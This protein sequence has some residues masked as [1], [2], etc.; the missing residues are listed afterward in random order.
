MRP[1]S[2][3]LLAFVLLVG[4]T[5]ATAA[6]AA[7][8][9]AA[10]LVSVTG[11]GQAPSVS[12]DGRYVAYESQS[13]ATGRWSVSVRDRRGGTLPATDG[14]TGDSRRPSLSPDGRYLAFDTTADNVPGI[15]LPEVDAA[16]VV[17]CDLDAAPELRCV[18][19]GADE[20]WVDD[21]APSL[22]EGAVTLSW[23][24]RFGNGLWVT[25]VTEF[26]RDQ[27]GGLTE[28]DAATELTP[29]DPAVEYV[30][31]TGAR[32][33][34][35]ADGTTVVFPATL[36]TMY[37]LPALTGRKLLSLNGKRAQQTNTPAVYA[38]T[39]HPLRMTRVDEEAAEPAVS[40]DGSVL[41]YVLDGKVVVDGPGGRREVAAG[42]APTLS[43]DGRYLAY[44][45]PD[46]LA[47]DL[48]VDSARAEAGLPP[49]AAEPVAPSGAGSAAA[50]SADGSTVVFDS[51]ASLAAVDGDDGRDVYARD[52]APVLAAPPTDFGVLPEGDHR[53]VSVLLRHNGFG[54]LGVSGVDVEGNGFEV[55]PEESCTGAVLYEGDECAVG[56]RF[57][58]SGS[59]ERAAA[60]VVTTSS[61]EVRVPLTGESVTAPVGVLSA[62]PVSVTFPGARLALTLSVPVPVTLTNGAATPVTVTGI[63]LF[64]GPHA[65]DFT[66]TGCAGRTLEPGERC[67][68]SVV[69]TPRGG[70]SR[71][72]ALVITTTDAPGS[73]VIALTAT[74]ATP[75]L[76]LD[77]A[78][79]A[80]G[81]VITV[82]G[83][84][85]PPGR[86]VTVTGSALPT[87]PVNADQT[88]RFTAALVT[89]GPSPSGGVTGVVTGTDVTAT[90]PL[91][92]VA[93]TYQP[94]GLHGRR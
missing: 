26:G 17:V 35:S 62:D 76:T 32:A 74:G 11:D 63:G 28:L 81:R 43:G 21:T 78:V 84:N 15:E 42:S 82:A 61:G 75:T 18:H 6:T 4:C 52:F 59:G 37:C 22:A 27:D 60:L 39:L 87:G 72:S 8:P 92:V 93:G 13:A 83:A 66:A 49:L 38:A 79:A 10:G 1:I 86:P 24:R 7:A 48:V 85:F 3:P 9:D 94:P 47:R 53:S 89:A 19:A 88:G 46:V 69:A 64:P 2:L 77:P 68:V 67:V 5:A 73:L 16:M 90:A 36:C 50:L 30:L 33:R 20:D 29:T 25:M 71:T 41:A 91:L 54:P 12:A 57:T 45:G 55:Y 58:A 80:G 34:V 65:A 14:L 40:G 44:R 70:G 56:V 31:G 51:A 23:T